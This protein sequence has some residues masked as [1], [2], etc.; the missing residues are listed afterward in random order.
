[1]DYPVTILLQRASVLKVEGKYVAQAK[2]ENIEAVLLEELRDVLIQ[3]F[4]Q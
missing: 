3:W 1:M 4:Q 2:G